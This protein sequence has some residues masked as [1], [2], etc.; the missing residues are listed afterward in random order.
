MK[1][2]VSVLGTEVLSVE[3]GRSGLCGARY[4][5]TA[6]PEYCIL[7]AG[8]YGDHQSRFTVDD[9]EGRRA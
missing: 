2:T 7:A 5:V 1:L 6:T 4:P 9:E 3:F 8:H